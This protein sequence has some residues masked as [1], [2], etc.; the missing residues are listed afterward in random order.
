M[1]FY[2]IVIIGAGPI[3]IACGLEA[4]K[5][6]LTYVILEKGPIVNSLYNYP[7]NMQ[8]FSSS[9]KLEIDEIPFISKEPKPKRSEALEYYRRIATSNKLQVHLFEKVNSITK[10]NTA[11]TV[12]SEKQTYRS[13]NVVIATGFYDLPN[14]INVSGENLPKVSHYYNDSHFYAGQKL[15]VIGASNSSVDAALECYRKGA[16]VTMVIRGEEVGHRVKYWVRPDIINRIEEGSIQVYYNSVVKEISPNTVTIQTKENTKIL[17]N[18]FVLAL[19]G[20]KPNF[21]LLEQVGIAFSKDEKR[22][23]VYN[24]DTM[25]TNVK[26]VYLAGVICGGMDTHKWFIENSRIHSKRIIAAILA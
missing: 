4:E 6:G 9:E 5:K 22:I 12:V 13:K 26:G 14:T 2:D 3:G 21:E 16:E 1:D 11:F 10:D 7:V 17:E 24:D 15:V 25:E 18:D 19:T 8:F 23:P 20:Y